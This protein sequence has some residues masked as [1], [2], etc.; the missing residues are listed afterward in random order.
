MQ[1]PWCRVGLVVIQHRVRCAGSSVNKVLVL[2]ACHSTQS[3]LILNM[4]IILVVY[5]VGTVVAE[6]VE[7]YIGP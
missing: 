3:S 2:A 1:V 6:V 5:T 4:F 7:V